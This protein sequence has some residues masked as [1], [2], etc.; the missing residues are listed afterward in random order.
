M[1]ERLT[2][3]KTELSLSDNIP[4]TSD[5]DRMVS[6]DAIARMWVPRTDPLP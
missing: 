3:G 1:T 5:G 4:L 2:C 6:R